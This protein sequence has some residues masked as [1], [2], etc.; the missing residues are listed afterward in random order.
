MYWLCQDF[1]FRICWPLF[2]SLKHYVSLELFVPWKLCRAHLIYRTVCD[3]CLLWREFL[4]YWIHALPGHRL[5]SFWSILFIFQGIYVFCMSFFHYWHEFFKWY[6]H[7]FSISAA[8]VQ[9]YGHFHS[10][11]CLLVFTHFNSWSVL[12]RRVSFIRIFKE[13]M[14]TLVAPFYWVFVFRFLIF[15]PSLYCFLNWVFSYYYFLSFKVQCLAVCF[16]SPSLPL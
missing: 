15:W 12:R 4:K 11:S 3:W 10:Q 8:S 1:I 9:S 6:S 7:Y 2:D 5:I 14:H 16:S 13:V